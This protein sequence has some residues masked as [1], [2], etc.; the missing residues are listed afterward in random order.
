MP[1]R[2]LIVEDDSQKAEQ[3]KQGLSEAGFDEI[4][5]AENAIAA[6][7]LLRDKFY[8]LV[9]LDIALP[10][11]D[12]EEPDRRGGIALFNEVTARELYRQPRHFIGFTGYE[13][14]FNEALSQLGAESW[15]VI[16]YDRTSS[17]WLQQLQ[18]KA[19]HIIASQTA[20]EQGDE[21]LCDIGVV[22]ALGDP[23]LDAVL[24]LKWDWKGDS[25]ESDATRYHLGEASFKGKRRTIVA[26]KA[27]GMGMAQAAILSTKLILRYRPRCIVMCGICAGVK[28]ADVSIGDVLVANPSWDYGSGKRLIKAGVRTFEPAPQ[29]YSLSTRVRGLV[30]LLQDRSD[31]LNDLRNEFPG[32]KPDSVVRVRIGPVASG[33]A[34]LADERVIETLRSQQNRKLLGIDMESYGVMAAGSEASAPRPEALIIKGVSD[35]ADSSKNDDFRHYAAHNSA[36]ALR[37]LIEQFGL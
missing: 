15:S 1:L 4:D 2:A 35:F 34:V 24:A 19:S 16:L 28:S 18:A 9:V 12:G 8:H 11:R 27:P 33:A 5:L 14:V 20:E 30:E 21:F 37:L 25:D 13:D 7:K 3:A 17:E 10:T 29:P 22:T 32:R 6:K 23:E 26:A 31:L 36:G